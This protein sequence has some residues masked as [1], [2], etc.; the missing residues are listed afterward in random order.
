MAIDLFQTRF[1]LRALEQLFPPKTFFLDTFFKEENISN[2]RHIDI[3]VMK[4]KR[5]LAPFVNPLMEGKIVEKLG[6][7][8]T[9]FE[10][11]YLK[12]KRVTTAVDIL[13][14]DFGEH[15][16]AGNQ[17]PQQKAGAQLAKEMAE[18]MEDIIRREEWMA[19]QA[20]LTGK[21]TVLGDGV[22]AII[23]FFMLASHLVTLAGAAL[24]SA[25][26]ANPL[27]DLKTWKR[28]IARDSGLVPDVVVMGHDA[29]DTFIDHAT[30]T[31][32]LDNRRIN[33]GEIEPR[34]LPNGVTFQGTL[35][36]IQCDLFTYDEWYLDTSA[37]LQPLM[38][39]KKV[40]MASTK[41]RMTR[42]YGAIQD[43]RS[44]A[45]VRMFHTAASCGALVCRHGQPPL[46]P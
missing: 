39:V 41:A 19:T 28:L 44:N 32:A 30:V 25:G 21:V 5:R 4:G 40:M 24:W 31:S 26:T 3:D 18:L 11:P 37:V 22:N 45:S 14:R 42:Q 12:P 7:T 16:Y 10:P 38:P 20:L 13:K 29:F 33:R 35:K 1:M 46:R 8:T 2:T 15:I 36:E 23:D 17:T 6:F 9:S 27:L 34:D 43:L